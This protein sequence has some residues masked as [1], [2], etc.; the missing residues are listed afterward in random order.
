LIIGGVLVALLGILIVSYIIRN[1]LESPNPVAPL[2]ATPITEAVVVTTRGIPA[3]E[4]L[5]DAD[6]TIANIPI[7]LVPLNRLTDKTL[8]IGKIAAAPMVAGEMVLP[9]RLSDSTNIIDR[10]LAF[11]IADDQVVLAFPIVDLMSQL[12]L[13]K[14]GDQVDI[15][16][17]IT[18]E[19]ENQGPVAVT[20][21]EETKTELFTFDA[22]QRLT[23]TAVVVE[24]VNQQEQ[25]TTP[26]DTSTVT[27][28]NATPA[29][30]PQPSRTE[31][32]PQAL[33][34]ALSPQDA[35]VLK[36]LKDAGAVFDIV[37]RSPTSTQFF[38]TNPV[39]EQ[40]IN[41]RYQLEAPR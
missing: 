16:A 20:E 32:D 26:I 19:V 9:H 25:A 17:S 33:L 11:D 23:I 14:R 40:Y 12:N 15:L 27:G 41:D 24:I 6:L 37:L 35:L 21:G 39:T 7:Q 22:M 34:L 38:E 4:V 1:V 10:S 8:A 36:H 29:P 31:A 5:T 30:P 2:Q 28:T 18:Q 13:L 3:G